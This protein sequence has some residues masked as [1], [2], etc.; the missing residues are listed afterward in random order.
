[1]T[2]RKRQA[3]ALASLVMAL[4]VCI[5]TQTASATFY[6]DQLF[7]W[8]AVLSPGARCVDN[9]NPHIAQVQVAYPAMYNGEQICVVGRQYATGGGADTYPEFCGYATPVT[10]A[11]KTEPQSQIGWPT[12]INRSADTIVVGANWDGWFP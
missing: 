11:W 3:A 7:C 4:S 5:G 8:N 6:G 1:M 12:V 9:E 10:G 2:I